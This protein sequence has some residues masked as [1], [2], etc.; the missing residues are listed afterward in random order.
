[1]NGISSPWHLVGVF[2]RNLLGPHM[3]EILVFSTPFPDCLFIEERTFLKLPEIIWFTIICVYN[4]YEY[5][6]YEIVWTRIFCTYYNYNISW[7]TYHFNRIK[8]PSLCLPI[9]LIF[10]L[11]NIRRTRS[12]YFLI[13]FA[14]ILSLYGKSGELKAV[15]PLGMGEAEAEEGEKGWWMEKKRQSDWGEA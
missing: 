13:I 1:M 15:W 2:C 12:A 3:I 4:F 8:C 7:L 14:T 6:F 10:I 9:S 11:S 5:A